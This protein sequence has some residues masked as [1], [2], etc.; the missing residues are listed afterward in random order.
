MSG[1]KLSA[2]QKMIGMM[3]LVLTALLALQVS[4]SVLD[5]FIL[6][7]KSLEKSIQKQEAENNIRLSHIRTAVE[8]TGNRLKDVELLEKA[9]AIKQEGNKVISYI[10]SLK[11]ELIEL[12]GGKDPRTG[13]PKGVKDDSGVAQ[14]MCNRKK[15]DELKKLLNGYM[16]YLTKTMGKEYKDIALDAKDSELFKNDPNQRNKCFATLNFDKTPLG[17]V[18]ATLSQFGTDVV[19]AESD[20]LEILAGKLGADDVKF[21]KIFP[22]VKPQS[23]IVAA[24]S[25]YHAELLLAA[26]SSV[27]EPEMSIDNK[28]IPVD[29]GIGKISFLATPGKYDENG[30]AKKTFKA[31]IKLKV[32]GGDSTFIKEIEYF[33]AKPVIQVQSA[34]VS[35]LYLNA[36]NELNIH[37]PA[38]GINYNPKF[39]AEGATVIPGQGKGL[40]TLIP[41]AP[42]VKVSVYNNGSFLDIITFKVRTIPRPEIQ[43]TAGGK[44]IN[45]RQGVP[46]PGPR[47]LE[48]RAIPDES[49]K[50]FLPKDARYRVAE[51]EVTLARGSRPIQIKK[52]TAQEISLT[53][54]AS[55]AQ[56]GDRIVVEIKK[57]ERLNYKDEIETVNVGTVVHNIPIN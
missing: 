30:L 34:A 47:K 20:A 21:D 36:G 13:R 56:A 3:Y 55:L 53:D 43:L 49:F 1:E 2:R 17:A 42:E 51:W 52:V 33:V 40:V 31:A 54:F 48:I 11:D 9:L 32:P 12:T 57:V 25:N 6:I 37:V 44:L 39:T 46:A 29:S 27:F 23:N 35:A 26:S 19:Y 4:S 18:L 22:L 15:A 28:K 45:E 24:G 16:Q 8:E 7:N 14:L 50:S 10:N 5:K 38:L 41:N